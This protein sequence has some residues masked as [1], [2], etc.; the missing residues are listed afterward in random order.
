VRFDGVP[1]EVKSAPLLGEHTEQVL[2]DWL[3]LD[4]DA[5]GALRRDGIV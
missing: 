5:V 1:T 3:G 4:K 2:G